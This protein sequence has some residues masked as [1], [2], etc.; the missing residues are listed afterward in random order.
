MGP[1]DEAAPYASRPVLI[2]GGFGFLGSNLLRTLVDAKARVRVLSRSFPTSWPD[3][4]LERIEFVRADLRDEGSLR[5]ACQGSE[6]I[7][8]LAGRSGAAASNAYPVE[9][10]DV[11]ARGQ[12]LLLD[13][14]R[15][16]SPEA[17]VVFASSRLVYKP[18]TDLPVSEDSPTGP[19][20]A[21][22]IHKLTAEHYHGL[23]WRLHG[24]RA[25]ILRITNPYG[26]APP[27]KQQN[28]YGIINWFINQAVNG[29]ELPVYGDGSQVR[30]Y[31]HVDDVVRAFLLAGTSEAAAGHVFNV[32]SGEPTPFRLMAEAVIDEAKA[33]S[34][35]SRSW[36]RDAALVETGN[37][38]ADIQLIKRKLGWVPAVDFKSGLQRVIARHP[39]ML[40]RSTP[41]EAGTF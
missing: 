13:T 27:D 1:L 37:F 15:R 16:V 3:D 20:S 32:G 30:D 25:V 19:L 24:I 17:T 41:V 11:N 18:T 33:G 21:Y 28:A 29:G 38:F 2:T 34:I 10:L 36:P 40:K 31:V 5:E 8:N 35:V 14:C 26:P 6:V 4:T 39:Q 12:L 23:F 7:F 22:G 9:D